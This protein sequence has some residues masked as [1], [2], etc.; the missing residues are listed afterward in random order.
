VQIAYLQQ[1][2]FRSY[3]RFSEPKC[4]MVSAGEVREQLRRAARIPE[5]VAVT[6]VI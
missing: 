5:R 2:Y 3:G 1:R 6:I 4:K